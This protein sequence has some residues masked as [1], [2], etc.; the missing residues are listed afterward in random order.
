MVLLK[1]CQTCQKWNYHY[2]LAVMSLS[3]MHLYSEWGHL[4]RKICSSHSFFENAEFFNLDLFW[5]GK[6]NI[7]Y[8]FIQLIHVAINRS[9]GKSRYYLSL[10]FW[11][12]FCDITYTVTSCTENE[13]QRY[14]RFL[15][16]M[17]EIVNRWHSAKE[18]FEEVN[19]VGISL[20]AVLA[21]IAALYLLFRKLTNIPMF[22]WL[23]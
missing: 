4:L 17:L 10:F 20:F 22:R 19:I 9:L 16:A 5:Q 2:L 23:D 3:K 21:N 6:I 13:A 1:V 7:A 15:A 18:I 8:R 12:I 14:G 11:Q